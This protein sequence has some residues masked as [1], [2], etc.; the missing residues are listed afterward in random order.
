MAHG[1][2]ANV[3]VSYRRQDTSHLAGRL[4]DR[5]ADRFGPTHVFMDVDSIEPGSDFYEV[6]DRAVS[7]SDVVVA[8]IGPGWSTAVDDRGRRR[9]DSPGDLV[10]SE[11]AAALRH[12][13]RLIPVLVDGAQMPEDDE[14]PAELHL[15]SRRHAVRLDHP[16]F[17]SDIET[18]INAIA[19]ATVQEPPTRPPMA[20]QPPAPVS[21]TFPL[22][23]PRPTVP[24]G[25]WGVPVTAERQNRRFPRRRILL[26]IGAISVLVAVAVISWSWRGEQVTVPNLSGKT[27]PEAQQAVESAQLVLAVPVTTPVAD[28]NLVDRVVDQVPAPGQQKSVR[29]TVQISVGGP[30]ATTARST[31]GVAPPDPTVGPT[32][33]GPPV[34]SPTVPKVRKVAVPDVVGQNADDAERGLRQ[35]GFAVR[36]TE[37]DAGGTQG[38]VVGTDPAAGTQV[39][40]GS[41]VTLQVTT[42]DGGDTEMP[43]VTGD[44]VF[45]AQRK[46]QQA[47]IT[48]LSV[49]QQATSDADADGRVLDQSPSPGT[50]VAPGDRV[51]LVVGRLSGSGPGGGN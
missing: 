39:T 42:G 18:L 46:L 4:Y 25:T 48:N 29:A 22:I 16:T 14:L 40:A 24:G 28:P 17:R 26:A 20:P 34:P 1:P 2:A 36:R 32:V 23:G 6:I 3:F 15:L 47:G 35:A 9:L 11:I 10:R 33:P 50:K 5:L 12:R 21:S 45:D 30:A 41:T 27:V 44:R 8:L 7:S 38:D 13:V 31:S 51:V 19:R 49:Q 43:D 37:V